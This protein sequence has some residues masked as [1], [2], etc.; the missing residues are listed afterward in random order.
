M[1]TPIRNSDHRL[2]VAL[3]SP[4]VLIGGG[5]LFAIAMLS[6]SI[7]ILYGGRQDAM[8]HSVEWSRNTL[9]VIERDLTHDI[10]LC[11]LSLQAVV[12]GVRR[13]DVMAAPTLI[14]R[15]MLFDR[16]TML[17]LAAIFVTDRT[18]RIVIDSRAD[19]P[20]EVNLADRDYF[21]IQR[22]APA[23][24][25]YL[26]PPRASRLL[27]GERVV[28]LSRRITDTDG[29]FRGVV[30]GAVSV[31]YF[32]ALLSGLNVGSHGAVALIHTDGALVMRLPGNAELTGRDMRG[33]APFTQMMTSAEGTFT[34]T[35]S[36]DG[37][38]R[39]YAFK[40]LS[41]LPLIAA[42]AP[43]EMDVYATW[44][45]RA[46]RVGAMMVLVCGAFIGVAIL[47][48]RALR[49]KAKAESALRTLAQTDSLTGLSNRRTL[50]EM[51]EREWRRAV[52]EHRPLSVLF[53]DLDRFKAYNDRY[54]HQAGDDVLAA[55]G[56]CLA[57]HVRR[58]GDLAAR[59]GGEEFVL[60]LPDTDSMGAMSIA[61]SVRKAVA[62]LAIEHA[63]SEQGRVTISVG[64]ASWQGLVAD[65][66]SSVVK[67]ADEALYRAKAI[68][69]NRVSAAI[70][71]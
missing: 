29:S 44:R 34:E 62:E 16:S 31:Q 68:G 69:R 67:A 55:V 30:V 39:V 48:A 13:P 51:L 36:I 54:G 20:P 65:S 61:E 32:S 26:S 15:A 42:V 6:I 14:R 27:N 7:A 56:R 53:V 11:D 50:D 58:P 37:I 21:R 12:D 23:W 9:L 35:A 8:Q 57:D 41:G 70:L 66:V 22:D 46:V 52:R 49:Q 1:Q 59:Y 64:A 40:H 5:V 33:S 18:G 47:L 63:G 45:A 3:G 2:S 71:A 43:A 28:Y 17:P 24:G 10:E 4:G 19:I 38:R 25:L 60:V